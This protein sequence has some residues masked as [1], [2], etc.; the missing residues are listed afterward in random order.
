M[1]GG[2]RMKSWKKQFKKEIEMQTPKLSEDVKNAPIPMVIQPKTKK[3]KRSIFKLYWPLPTA[4]LTALVLFISLWFGLKSTTP[5]ISTTHVYSLDINP[6]FVFVS[7]ENGKVTAVSSLNEDADV[8][9]SSVDSFIDKPISEAIT[10]CV[11]TSAKLGYFDL[12]NSG[13]AVLVRGVKEDSANQLPNIKESIYNYFCTK[14]VYGI[15][16]EEEISLSQFCQNIGISTTQFDDFTKQIQG[17]ESMFGSR[18]VNEE[19]L[20]T[21]YENYIL[22]TQMFNYIQNSLKTNLDQIFNNASLLLKIFSLNTDIMI[23]EDNPGIFLKD[24]WSLV[25]FS[26]KDD[27]TPAFAELMNQMTDVLTQYENQFGTRLHT[28][29]DLSA[30]LETYQSLSLENIR[31]LENLSME[32]FLSDPEFYVSILKAIGI[33]THSLDEILIAPTSVEEYGLQLS[34]VLSVLSQQKEFEF[35]QIY[36]ENR[37]ELDKNHYEEFIQSIEKEYGSLIN[38]WNSFKKN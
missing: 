16:V 21:I 24:Y 17:L 27:Y 15:Y 20:A 22:G 14:G 31:D 12:S 1:E 18:G 37:S 38:Y 34:K 5:S 23:H 25:Q 4:I 9:L 32:D 6:S 33:D 30:L 26:N 8:V 28:I 13:D 19:N 3:T 2:D 29:Q 35:E 10:L 7:D 11:D 36:E